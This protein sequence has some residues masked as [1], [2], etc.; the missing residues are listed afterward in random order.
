MLA[1]VKFGNQSKKSS[2]CQIKITANCIAYKVVLFSGQKLSI[3]KYHSTTE[4]W[5]LR[6]S[7]RTAITSWCL[8]SWL[9][10]LLPPNVTSLSVFNYCNCFE[11]HFYLLQ[12]KCSVLNLGAIAPPPLNLKEHKRL[13]VLIYKCTEVYW[14]LH[15]VS[16]YTFQNIMT[17]AFRDCTHHIPSSCV[18]TFYEPL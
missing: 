5:A 2:N 14:F 3:S 7:K 12:T 15:N 9:I 8:R 16:F 1:Y 4:F 11:L 6:L 10:S 13:N 18:Y 17:Y